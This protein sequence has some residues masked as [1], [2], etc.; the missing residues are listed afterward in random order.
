MKRNLFSFLLIGISFQFTQSQIKVST[1]NN[2]GI[3]IE[4]P[5][6][7]LSV[8]NSGNTSTK[9]YFE[10]TM[11]SGSS[12]KTLQVFQ[13]APT[14]NCGWAFGTVSSIGVGT[15]GTYHVGIYGSAY[16]SSPISLS[17][18]FGGYFAAGNAP[19][20]YNYGVYGVIVG[21]NNGAAIFA[22]TPN[23]VSCVV[24]G[25][26][27]AYLRGR[28]YI[29]ENVGIRN[30][31]PQYSLDVIGDINATG[32]IRINGISISSDIS[33][34][35]DIKILETGSLEKLI[36]LNG[37]T[38]KYKVPENLVNKMSSVVK[39][40][41]G[42]NEEPLSIPNPEFYETE[43]IGFIAQDLQK[44]LPQLVTE[45]KEGTL[46]INYIGLIPLMVEAIKEQE[47]TIKELKSEIELLKSNSKTIQ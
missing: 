23:K 28:V 24:P 40:D 16:P 3:G 31:N 35:E 41:T 12:I 17:S 4:T 46:G 26:F 22:G 9:V 10:N 29:E 5:V 8:G 18:T 13:P 47:A 1:N 33:L 11:L 45:N 36:Q 34:K 37:V 20:G 43:Q 7:K 42:T 15:S 38:Y 39:S 25:M 27:A 30:T 2:V 44:V 19:N 14:S 32:L 6:S 21:S